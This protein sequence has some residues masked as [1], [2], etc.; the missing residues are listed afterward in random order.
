MAAS[1]FVLLLSVSSRISGIQKH[2][3]AV[4]LISSNKINYVFD[5]VSENLFSSFGMKVTKSGN[6]ILVT[7][8]LPSEVSPSAG[9]GV[10]ANFTKSHYSPS[11]LNVSFLDK[12]YALIS[13][14]SFDLAFSVKP[15]SLNYTYPASTKK[16]LIITNPENSFSN[17]SQ[18]S[19][20]VNI[21]SHWF[22]DDVS[23]VSCTPWSPAQACDGGTTY[24]L[25]FKL[26]LV[27]RNNTVHDSACTAFDVDRRS[28]LT[29]RLNNETDST[30]LKITAG[31]LPAV[32]SLDTGTSFVELTSNFSFVSSD[33]YIDSLTY[34]KVRDLN[35]NFSRV[36][37]A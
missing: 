13:Q 35:T 37:G 25:N 4:D 21:T 17:I 33:F 11:W 15:F 24:C 3:L 8:F 27:D 31:T 30:V 10:Y 2:P 12:D 18:I 22:R 1:M 9:I 7:D 19:Y 14:Q 6:N 26:Y 16:E 20:V 36:D 32:V 5:D 28:T 23:D 29:F 34:L